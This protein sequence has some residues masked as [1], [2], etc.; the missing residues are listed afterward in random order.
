MI[1]I[2]YGSQVFKWG[3]DSERL[4]RDTGQLIVVLHV[5]L[6]AGVCIEFSTPQG[7]DG[8]AF[9]KILVSALAEVTRSK[10]QLAASSCVPQCQ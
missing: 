1:S 6:E 4:S 8:Y 10:A 9:P 3:Q 5:L 7:R 2:N